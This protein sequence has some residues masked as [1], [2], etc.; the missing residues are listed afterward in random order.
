MTCGIEKGAV[1]EAIRI[2]D[3]RGCSPEGFMFS[4]TATGTWRVRP[5]DNKSVVIGNVLL[6]EAFFK[7]YG[8]DREISSLKFKGVNLAKLAEL[9]WF[10]S[11]DSF[12]I[13]RAHEFVKE[14]A[15][16]SVRTPGVHREGVQPRRGEPGP[17]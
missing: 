7:K 10:T 11:L 9:F 8:L 4:K 5:N 2:M 3:Q 6:L 12:S 14:L 16:G 1:S 17:D 15:Y 13:L